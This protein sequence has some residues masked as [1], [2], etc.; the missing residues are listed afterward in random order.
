MDTVKALQNL[1]KEQD[2]EMKAIAAKVD[3]LATVLKSF[4]ERM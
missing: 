1:L 3:I 2:E 4:Q